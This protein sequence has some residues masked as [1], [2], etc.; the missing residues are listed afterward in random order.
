MP[1][2]TDVSNTVTLPRGYQKHGGRVTSEPEPVFTAEDAAALEAE[3]L[4]NLPEATIDSWLMDETPVTAWVPLRTRKMK[5]MVRGMTED[6]RASIER[7]APRTMNRQTR[8]PEPD[9]NWMNLEIVKR[10]LV[11]PV[12]PDNNLLKRALAGELAY[13]AQEIGR[14][15]GFE[16]GDALG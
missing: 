11:S 13:L 15:S 12:I 8:R 14:V 5:V 9:Q 2:S 6:E 7:D 10:A 4:E 3:E 16:L 1:G